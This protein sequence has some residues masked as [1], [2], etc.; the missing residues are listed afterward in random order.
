MGRKLKIP[1]TPTEKAK[2]KYYLK[3]KSQQEWQTCPHCKGTGKIK[4]EN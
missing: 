2:Q 1:A 3:K 4:K